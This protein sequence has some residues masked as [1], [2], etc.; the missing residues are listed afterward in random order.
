MSN[1]IGVDLD[2]TIVSYDTLLFRLAL[3]RG[4][5]DSSVPMIKEKIR[6]TMRQAGMEEQWIELQGYLYGPAMSEA[7]MFSGVSDFFNAMSKAGHTIFIISH[8]TRFPYRGPDYDLHEASRNWLFQHGFIGDGP[9]AIPADHVF[10]LQ[11]Q[12]Q[13][14]NTIKEKRCTHF[15]DDL[16]EFL[17]NP[18]FPDRVE[19]ILFSPKG[20]PSQPVP[21]DVPIMKSWKLITE[22]FI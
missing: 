9:G 10:L 22:Y 21:P 15:I 3:M 2:N 18:A 13:K 5:I 4:Y 17:L 7:E 14:W 8:K 19:R 12:E 11:T 20:K 6:N 16:P 1:I